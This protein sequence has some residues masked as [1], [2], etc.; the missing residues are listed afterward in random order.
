MLLTKHARALRAGDSDLLNA[1]ALAPVPD[2]QFRQGT[3]VFI[4]FV[5][6][7][8]YGDQEVTSLT[9]KAS[10]SRRCES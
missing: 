4:G 8:V 9:G 2:E 10:G 6:V 3:V 7:K 1:L 5:A